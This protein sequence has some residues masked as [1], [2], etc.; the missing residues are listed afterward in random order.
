MANYTHPKILKLNLWVF[1]FARI[2]FVHCWSLMLNHPWPYVWFCGYRFQ[3]KMIDW[4]LAPWSIADTHGWLVSWFKKSNLGVGGAPQVCHAPWLRNDSWLDL[5][6]AC[7]DGVRWACSGL[8]PWHEHWPSFMAAQVGV[9]EVAPDAP[10]VPGCPGYMTMVT[11]PRTWLDEPLIHH[12]E[13]N[14][15]LTKHSDLSRCLISKLHHVPYYDPWVWY[16][17]TC[18]THIQAIDFC[19]ENFG[20]YAV[21]CGHSD[22]TG[23]VNGGE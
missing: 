19:V 1:F 9:S 21:K 17:M 14:R 5:A 7:H 22:V 20:T 18:K 4:R 3:N 16:W 6:V 23:S 13:C 2:Y 8:S 11:S 12:G 15:L 10:G